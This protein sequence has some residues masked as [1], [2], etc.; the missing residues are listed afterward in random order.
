VDNGSDKD[1]KFQSLRY[2]GKDLDLIYWQIDFLNDLWVQSELTFDG[3]GDAPVVHTR[4]YYI[5]STIDGQTIRI[6]RDRDKPYRDDF[7]VEIR[8]LLRADNYRFNEP[9]ET[10]WFPDLLFAEII[11]ADGKRE[12]GTVVEVPTPPDTRLFGPTYLPKN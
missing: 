8:G 11:F 4:Q 10:K 9:I 12:V 1:S 2:F 3:N 6:G 5:L 7:P